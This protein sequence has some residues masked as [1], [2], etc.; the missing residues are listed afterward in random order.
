MTNYLDKF[1]LSTKACP[2]WLTVVWNI[3]TWCF[4]IY[5][6]DKIFGRNFGCPHEFIGATDFWY[7]FKCL[8]QI[9]FFVF[10]HQMYVSASWLIHQFLPKL[11]HTD[12]QRK[13]KRNHSRS[14][15]V[16]LKRFWVQKLV[17]NVAR[18]E[19]NRDVIRIFWHFNSI[20][21]SV[22]I[23][24]DIFLFIG[25]IASTTTLSKSVICL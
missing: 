21:A 19:K 11:L 16:Y 10:W 20:W 25:T 18:F 6:R 5:L 2:K 9:R 17:G 15:M 4:N 7:P 13:V 14:E 24:I 22:R 3:I 8:V 23:L 1:D 12:L